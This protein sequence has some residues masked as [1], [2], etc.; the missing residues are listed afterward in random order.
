MSTLRAALLISYKAGTDALGRVAVFAIL[1][2]AT[3]VLPVENVGHLTLFT[4][5]GWFGAAL[6]DGGLQ[7]YVAGQISRHPAAAAGWF[8]PILRLRLLLG[9]ITIACAGLAALWL[10]PGAWLG[11][12]LVA[13]API[14][15]S[16]TELVFHGFRGL[17]RSDL[18]ASLLLAQRLGALVLTALILWRAP[19]LAGVG[20]ALSLPAIASFFV[21]RALMQRLA[22]PASAQA[23]PLT[24]EVWRRMVAPVGLGILLSVA[25]YRIDV[26]LLSAWVPLTE[27]AAYGAVFRLLEGFRLIPAAT[28]AVVLPRVFGPSGA[29][30]TG[31][32]SVGL[33]LMGCVA[34]IALWLRAEDIVQLAYGAA[35]TDA[36]P[37]LQVLSLSLPWLAVNM[38]LTHRLIAAGGQSTYA[39]TAAAALGANV[40]ANTW[41]I[42]TYGAS[43]AALATVLTEG[44]VTIGCVCGLYRTRVVR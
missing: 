10:A 33:G 44:V 7:L 20:L 19:S 17:N 29:R 30:F 41:L 3:R 6:G 24:V 22:P 39:L 27:V 18:E 12:V 36:A 1:V 35:Y 23:V 32:L 38:A 4:T 40:A 2:M 21:A 8:W 25:Y 14:V 42:P 13:L 5:I 9:A 28:L 31:Y 43:G 15:T 34:C 16:F 37:L 11:A 26:L